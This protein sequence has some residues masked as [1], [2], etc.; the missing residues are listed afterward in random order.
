MSLSKAKKIFLSLFG[1]CKK[2]YGRLSGAI[3]P[4]MEDWAKGEWIIKWGYK[5]NV[6]VFVIIVLLQ[7]A[8]LDLDPFGL[9]DATDDLSAQKVHQ[10]FNILYPDKER[11]SYSVILFSDK[12]LYHLESESTLRS[13]NGR[14]VSQKIVSSFPPSYEFQ[15]E[16]L[17]RI[18]QYKP[19]AIFIDWIFD[20]KRSG[21]SGWGDF[22]REVKQIVVD[23]KIPIFIASYNPDR[24]PELFKYAI[25]V[26]PTSATKTLVGTVSN[27]PLEDQFDKDAPILPTPAVAIYHK[28]FGGKI[29]PSHGNYDNEMRV[30]WGV[31]PSVLT[32][33]WMATCS[34]EVFSNKSGILNNIV[35]AYNRSHEDWP[36]CP[37]ADSTLVDDLFSDKQDD[38]LRAMLE[39]RV[40]AY[41]ANVSGDNDTILN[42]IG[43]T[44]PGVYYH[45][46]ALDNFLTFS[47]N[48]KRPA[49]TGAWGLIYEAV[50]ISTNTLLAFL[51]A[52]LAT[53]QVFDS[54]VRRIFLRIGFVI[55]VLIFMSGFVY[56]M[57]QVKNIAIGNWIGVLAV[58][59][60]AL[61]FNNFLNVRVLRTVDVNDACEG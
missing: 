59:H 17:S 19:R 9:S 31:K 39:D 43:M 53:R 18:S 35:S 22:V 47:T 12:S 49:A 60:I 6:V 57:Y 54:S 1:M 7:M 41:G 52:W 25:P 33:K 15:A 10:V 2:G 32:A 56:F 8:A 5:I 14:F 46:M 51:I 50:F 45:M 55:G 42:P 16:V 36:T 44:I 4:Y 28:V 34:N 24:R 26:A 20:D 29:D 61:S 30:I 13:V 27:Y 48:Y 11:K 40:V 21:V 23:K 3:S 37:Y 58:G 38:D